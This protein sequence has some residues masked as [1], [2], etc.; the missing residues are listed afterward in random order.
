MQKVNLPVLSPVFP[1]VNDIT[2]GSKGR[3]AV[4]I[5]D[6]GT[7]GGCREEEK[8]LPGPCQGSDSAA[9]GKTAAMRRGFF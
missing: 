6:L 7:V 3:R 5:L 2:D 8:I 4:P 9:W 1:S